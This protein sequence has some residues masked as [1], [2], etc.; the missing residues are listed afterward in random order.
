MRPGTTAF[1]RR[2]KSKPADWPAYEIVGTM[3]HSTMYVET[4]LIQRIY[5]AAMLVMKTFVAHTG[6]IAVD[7]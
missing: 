6:L 2:G 7:G 1:H 4:G 3:V 5:N